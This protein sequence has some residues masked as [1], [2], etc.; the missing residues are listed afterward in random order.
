[1][2]Q[3][4]NPKKNS[5]FIDKKL[6]YEKVTIVLLIGIMMCAMLTGCGKSASATKDGNSLRL[7]Y[8]DIEKDDGS[9]IYV[10]NKD[11]TFSPILSDM[12]GYSGSTDRA[13]SERYVWYTDNKT[14]ITSLIPTVTQGTPL[15][16][17][18]DSSDDMPDE[19]YLDRY[20]NK[21]YTV[22]MHITLGDDKSMQ[23][24]SEDPLSGSSAENALSQLSADDD[25]Y[26]ISAISGS[27]SLPINNVDKNMMILLGFEKNKV[28]TF[29]FYQGTKLQKVDIYADTR[30]FQSSQ[31]I[32][33]KEPYKKTSK[34][35]FIINLPLNLEDGYYYLSDLGF[36]R[37][38]SN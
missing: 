25:S 18:Y 8:E 12:P 32:S 17:I 4:K 24:L 10:L 36:F 30:I 22:G 29:D 21:G 35:Y 5:F 6:K 26:N 27:S 15:V 3:R 38:S 16:A 23:I 14:N 20:K 1:M 34:G 13:S 2:E 28:Y 11:K 37:Y 7:S 33:L 9:G 19:W 31:Y